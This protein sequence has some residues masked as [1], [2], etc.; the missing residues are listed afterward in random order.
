LDSYI[1]QRESGK[2]NRDIIES[3]GLLDTRDLEDFFRRWMKAI[4]L[5]EYLASDKVLQGVLAWL[6]AHGDNFDLYVCTNRQDKPST[7]RQI[8]E[9]GLSEFFVNILVTEQRFSKAQL[10]SSSSPNVSS[11]DWII[12]D[13]PEDVQEGKKLGLRT[14][15]VLTGF[16]NE[17]LLSIESP[18]LILNSL[19]DFPGTPNALS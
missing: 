7:K 15:A 3:E 1:S 18:S 17:A 9:L 16:T 14:C 5:P 8:K 6:E 2:S 12:G 13:S 10:I 19:R 4:E 11:I